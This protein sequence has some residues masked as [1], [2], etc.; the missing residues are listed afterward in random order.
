MYTGFFLIFRNSQV[1][2][3]RK[4]KS[5]GRSTCPLCNKPVQSERPKKANFPLWGPGKK[6]ENPKSKIELRQTG[7]TFLANK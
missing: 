7:E 3:F 4:S 5:F 1:R 6:G 2:T